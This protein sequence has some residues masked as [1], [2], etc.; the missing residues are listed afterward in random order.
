[1]AY[2]TVATRGPWPCGSDATYGESRGGHVEKLER[3]L[4]V[5]ERAAGLIA[6]ARERGIAIEREASAEAVRVR[7]Q[8]LADARA[9]VEADTAT[10]LEGARREADEI[11]RHAEAARADVIDAARARVP[12]AV[13]AVLRGLA[14]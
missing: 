12:D 8:T 3:I 1:M 2:Y 7:Q 11:A 14:D 4:D 5:E 6:E 10:L 13:A 9:A